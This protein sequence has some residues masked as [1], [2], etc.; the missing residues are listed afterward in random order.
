MKLYWLTLI[1]FG[2]AFNLTVK[3]DDT[4][5]YVVTEDTLIQSGVYPNIIF[6]MDTSGSMSSYAYDNGVKVGTR[7]EVVRQ[8]ATNVIT[9]TPNINISIMRFN[10]SGSEGGTISSPMLPIDGTGVIDTVK[11]VLYSFEAKGGTPIT[12]TIYEAASYLRGDPV[13]YGY[14][15]TD[16]DDLCMTWE[17]KLVPV[18]AANSNSRSIGSSKSSSQAQ[19]TYYMDTS[20]FYFPL[21]KSE[22][23][24]LQNEMIDQGTMDWNTW[25]S[26]DKWVQNKLKKNYGI[27]KNNYSSADVPWFA[28]APAW[29]WATIVNSTTGAYTNWEDL[30]P[31]FQK[32]LIGYGL[33]EDIYTTNVQ[34]AVTPPV[35]DPVEEDPVVEDP[36]DEDVEY[37]TVYVCTEYLNLDDAI[38]GD[39]YVSPITD[40]CQSNHIILFSDGAPNMDTSI[41]STVRELVKTLPAS[42][43]ADMEKNGYELEDGSTDFNFTTSCSGEGGCGEELAYYLNNT[44]NSDLSGTQEITVHAVGGYLSYR[45]EAFMDRIAD[46]GGGIFGN[47]TDT[48]SLTEVL[49]EIFSS[50]SES[51]GTFSAPAASVNAFNSMEHLDELYYSVF[52]PSTDAAWGGNVKRYR[53]NSDGKIVGADG[54]V[55]VDPETGYFKEDAISYWTLAED[56]YDGR[57]VRKGGAARRIT[58]IP[59]RNVTTY[60][61]Y[62]KS[63][64]DSTNLITPS[65]SLITTD[66]LD[67]TKT[68]DDFTKQILWLQGYTGTS[69]TSLTPRK[70]MEDPLHSR[71]VVLHYGYTTTG[72]GEKVLDST[73]FIGTNSG[74]LH[75]FNTNEDYPKEHFSF[76]PKELL[77]VA[78]QY[79]SST[80]G[81][82]YGLDGP[83]T[84]HHEDTNGNRMVDDGEKAY[85]YVGMRRGGR[86]YYALDISD[87]DNPK[88]MWQINGGS[89]DF[90]ELG[91]TWSAIKATSILWKGSEKNVLVFAGGYDTAE[92]DNVERLEHEMGNAIFIVDPETGKLLWKASDD[93]GN[94]KLKEMTSAIVGDLEPIDDNGDG[95]ADLIYFADLGG[96]IWRLDF[97][98]GSSGAN[99]FA[100]GGV[101]A[102]LG[103]DGSTTN[104]VRFYNSVDVIYSEEG[105]FKDS[106]D[107]EYYSQGRYQLAIGSGYRAHPLDGDTIDNFYVVNDFEIDGPPSNYVTIGKS[108]LANYSDY[109]TASY[110]DKKRGIYF[111]LP[112]TSE[113][114]LSNSV[115]LNNTI[116][117]TTYRPSDG[118][119][120]SGCEPDIGDG[121]LYALQLIYDYDQ[122]P[123]LVYTDVD[124]PGP[125]TEPM[126]YFKDKPQLLLPMTLDNP[127]WVSVGEEGEGDGDE[128]VDPLENLPSITRS[129]WREL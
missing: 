127:E 10:W 79:A 55:A 71:P 117:F 2:L 49:V 58:D 18:S 77:P 17:E 86:N 124:T 50:I 89:G 19:Q 41:N 31:W 34:G 37:E 15:E 126:P 112:E 92:D 30:E 125:L 88:F 62:S 104:H 115:T 119:S 48:S 26:L 96:R 35:D 129:Y 93:T 64:T 105:Y 66:L 16:N 67:S 81:K 32:Q 3:A 72:S 80:E 94:L 56:G 113:K 11:E 23:Y 40:S 22:P 107:G 70:Q 20:V 36:V 61:G 28:V 85:L 83:I 8:V 13:K 47:G 90:E 38:D 12:E 122:T 91:Q 98:T 25:K 102:D 74:Y 5:I 68:G 109:D 29:M 42:D 111:E 44:D 24:L 95:M 101:I 52:E 1:A 4:E 108:D 82:L 60:L 75:A 100:Q 87:R 65:N 46:Y 59:K 69:L 123:S 78:I 54:N 120:K 118:T 106:S 9:S 43:V 45:M 99:D 103:K 57:D 6:V 97:P 39:N 33:T 121:R 21:L 7:L 116:Y 63:L 14:D 114:S 84:I 110:S 51:S 128:A 76:I 73:L 27:K 53:M